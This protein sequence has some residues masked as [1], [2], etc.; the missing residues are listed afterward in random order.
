[1][2][3]KTTSVFPAPH[4][5]KTRHSLY[6]GSCR[7]S[8]TSCD[9]CFCAGVSSKGRLTAKLR[10]SPGFMPGSVF[11]PIAGLPEVSS[12]DVPGDTP[13]QA[14]DAFEEPGAP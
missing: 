14:A 8:V 2:A 3:S 7:K 4:T 6:P 13:V 12:R 5:A 11:W 10:L 1:M 9:A